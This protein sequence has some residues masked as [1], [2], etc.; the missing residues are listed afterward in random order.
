MTEEIQYFLDEFMSRTSGEAARPEADESPFDFAVLV[1]G[2]VLYIVVRGELEFH[3]TDRF[4]EAIDPALAEPTCKNV[5]VHMGQVSF[6]DSTGLATLVNA[7]Q[8]VRER[9]G[10][11]YL[12]G[13]TPFVIKTLEIT[14][15]MRVFQVHE[16]FPDAYD[17]ANK[18]EE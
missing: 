18:P 12:A 16:T 7:S 3:H 2:A 8:I 17:A 11:V 14:R 4:N 5:V 15:L 6:V 1:Q 13:C 9:G 10:H